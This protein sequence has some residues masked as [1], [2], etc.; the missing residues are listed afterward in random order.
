MRGHGS[1]VV[2]PNLQ[3]A[4]VTA[5]YLEETARLTYRARCIGTPIYFTDEEVGRLSDYVL[6]GNSF[7]RA[8]D[9]YAGRLSQR[10][11]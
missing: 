8:W 1:T 11:D 2:G 9:Y 4:V 6:A 10:S 5:I 7:N 3:Q